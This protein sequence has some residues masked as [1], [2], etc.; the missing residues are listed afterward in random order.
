MGSEDS[1]ASPKAPYNHISL[2]ENPFT[3]HTLLLDT[4]LGLELLVLRHTSVLFQSKV[5]RTETS[6]PELET[7][8]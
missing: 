2:A 5:T 1:C 7:D 8:S 3:S 6:K 4:E